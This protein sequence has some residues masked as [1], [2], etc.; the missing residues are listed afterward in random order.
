MTPDVRLEP[1][2]QVESPIADVVEAPRQPDED[3]PPATLVVE[4]ALE[5]GLDGLGPGDEI[6]VLTWLH[7][8]RRDELTTHPRND[9]T[10]PEQGVFSTRS[11]N[12][13]N[14]IGLHRTRIVAIEGTRVDVDHLEA[15]DGTPIIDIKPALG[16]PSDR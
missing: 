3:A 13:P 11:P 10:R 1:I 5:E 9:P 12:R 14:P 6:L 2:G 8:G 7:A 15:I 16:S 4:P